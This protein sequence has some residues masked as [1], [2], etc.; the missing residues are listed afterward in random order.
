L[1]NGAAYEGR[2]DLGNT[3][4][5]DGPRFKGRGL[6]QLTGRSNYASYGKYA[7]LNLLQKGNE[8]LIST[9]P[10]YA[11]DVS[12]WFWE[13]QRLNLYADADNLMVIT[14]RLKNRYL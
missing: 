8:S 5:G 13:N 14:S 6:I 7:N 10:R 2:S 9:I 12:L 3:K 4:K 1:A 11:L